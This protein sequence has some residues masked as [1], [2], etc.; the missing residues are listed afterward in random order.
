MF[1]RRALA[2]ILA[3]TF[4]LVAGQSLAAPVASSSSGR[5]AVPNVLAW[6][7]PVLASIGI[8]VPPVTEAKKRP[9][10]GR[11]R[12]VDKGAGFPEPGGFS[13]EPVG[14][15]DGPEAGGTT[16]RSHLDEG[17][18]FPEPGG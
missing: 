18:G 9:C 11:L 15:G 10:A 16:G 17:A 3:T 14:P 13:A 6:L 12:T 5:T 7:Q 1:R 8:D 2:V 4:V